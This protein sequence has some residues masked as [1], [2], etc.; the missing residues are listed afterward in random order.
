MREMATSLPFGK[1][2]EFDPGS[3]SFSAYL[4]RVEIF[5]AAND[6]A[7]EKKVPIFLNT[8]GATVY[9]TLRDLLAPASPISTSLED[10]TSVLKAHF[11]PKSLV[12]VERFHFHKRDQTSEETVSEYIAE[13]RRLATKCVF[14]G[15]LD[16]ALRDRFVCGLRSEATQKKL[17]TE[18]ALTIAKAVEV[19][20]SMEAAHKNAQAMKPVAPL[21]GQVAPNQEH[22]DPED[23]L[24][25][26]PGRLPDKPAPLQGANWPRGCYRCGSTTHGGPECSHRETTCH[27]CGKVGHLARVCRSGRARR[28]N[29]S[30]RGRGAMQ[31]WVEGQSCQGNQEEGDLWEVLTAS[32][33]VKPYRATL[34]LNDTPVQMEIDTGAAVTLISEVTLKSLLPHLALSEPTLKLRTYT[35]Q[36]IE[37]LGQARVKV[38]YNKYSGTHVLTVVKGTGPSLLGRDWLSCI[39]LD[40]AAIRRVESRGQGD[41][42]AVDQLLCQYAE[43][44]AKTP[45]TMK[46]IR[47]HLTLREGAIPR[48]RPPRSVPYAIRD[49]VG[50]E[51]DRLEEAGVLRKVSH[52]MWAAPLVPVPK[53]DGTLRLCGDYKVTINP[54]L[55]VD[56]YPLP[57]PV[58][59]MACLTGGVCF[60]KLDLSS[61]YQQML[62]DDASAKLV[63]INTHQGLYEYTRL[64]F[65]VASAPAVFQRAMDTILRG[66]PQVICYLDDILITGKTVAEHHEHLAEVLRRLQDHGL[67][68]KREKCEFAVGSVE[69]LGHRIDAR[70]VH[71]TDRKVKTILDTPAPTNI[72]KLRSFLGMISYYAKFIPNLAT[73]LHPLYTLLRANQKWTWSPDCDQAFREA[74]SLL[75]V[76]PILAHYDPDRPIVLATDASAYGQ[77]AV[78]SQLNEDG[79]EQP[80][81]FASR[82]LSPSECNYSQLDKEA[83]S[84]MF[85]VKRFHNYLY[86]RKFTLQT[87]HKP[88]TSIL[89]PKQGI[90][91]LAAARLQRWAVILSA[92]NYDIVYRPTGAHANADGLSRLPLPDSRPEGN[93][94]DTTIFMIGQLEALPV[95]ALAVAA[96]TASDTTLKRVVQ[97]LRGGWPRQVP[98]TLLPFWRRRDEMTLEG[99]CILW[100]MRVVIPK[101]L[102]PEVV[103]EL[104]RGHPGIVRMKAMARSHVWW[105]T[106]DKDIEQCVRACE[107]CQ[108]SRNMPARAPLHTWEW[109]ASPWER[110][111]VDFAGPLRGKMLLVVTDAHSKWPEVVVLTSTTAARTIEALRELFARFGIPRQ[112]VSDNG[113]QFISREFAS[114][115]D[116]MGVKHIKTAPYHPA[117]NGAA[118]R[119]VQSVKRGVRAGMANGVSLER[120]LQAF[121]LQYRSTPHATTGLT[122][123]VLMLGRDIRTRLDLLRPELLERVEGRQAQQTK[124][125]N[126]HCKRRELAVGTAV[127]ARNWREGPAWVRGHIRETTGPV[128]F[129]VELEDGELWRRHID[130]LRERLANDP[131]ESPLA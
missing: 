78:L 2:E 47:A 97:Y 120:A 32:P 95:Q 73:L 65:G 4:E 89:G 114:F 13:L 67:H 14:A 102:Q 30:P 101:K 64:P 49:M 76:A 57:K 7:D 79:T 56:Q 9:S 52:A 84:L 41:S 46:H 43:V 90:P 115:L 44:F 118:E 100:G 96:E 121:L 103:A 37:V 130:H 98:E 17:L 86:G 33:Q 108:A 91:P 93:P 55:L 61:A 110:I 42:E 51:L 15:H 85:G 74:K 22:T 36:P 40:W 124:Y 126:Q 23:T 66:I 105:V 26:Q 81:S 87:D 35:A 29:R 8:I 63:T 28:G 99:G 1:L 71:T 83:L 59:L 111:H 16:E 123:S 5:F 112:L 31:S 34:S 24:T 88:L 92:Y 77:G 38:S 21:V 69:Y 20:L 10:I 12:I 94:E 11:E 122:P 127:W 131:N 53:K 70:G 116:R 25:I 6:I 54:E 113:P 104:H 62:L 39:K 109:P 50:R 125:H 3:S 19:A 80:I 106:V 107:A 75:T 128:S 60:S 18:S 58:D 72:A 48:V 45:G 27:K 129:L 119:M 82:T 68:L 117:S